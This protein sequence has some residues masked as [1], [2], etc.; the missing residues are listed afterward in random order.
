M[1]TIKERKAYNDS[2]EKKV[3]DKKQA[4]IDDLS[5]FKLSEVKSREKMTKSL[6]TPKERLMMHKLLKV[7]NKG[8]DYRFLESCVTRKSITKPQRHVLNKIYNK[9]KNLI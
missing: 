5:N 2:L 6:M 1:W 9:Y 8:N 7:S 4:K 3:R